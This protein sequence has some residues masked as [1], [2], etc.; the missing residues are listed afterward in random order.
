MIVCSRSLRETFYLPSRNAINSA[1]NNIEIGDRAHVK[2]S[3]ILGVT[4]P[5]LY[6]VMRRLSIQI[7]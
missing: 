2:A 5:T 7:Q 4:R 6:D 3:K 1:V